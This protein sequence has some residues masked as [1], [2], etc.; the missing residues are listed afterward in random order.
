VLAH[1]AAF[2]SGSL[3]AGQQIAFGRVRIRATGRT[4]APGIGSPIPWADRA[5]FQGDGGTAAWST[6]S[7]RRSAAYAALTVERWESSTCI[8]ARSTRTSPVRPSSL[9]SAPSG[10]ALV[11]ARRPARSPTSTAYDHRGGRRRRAHRTLQA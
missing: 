3:S 1:E 2:G 7:T 6:S 8:H 10:T 4:P 9:T 5:V 11:S